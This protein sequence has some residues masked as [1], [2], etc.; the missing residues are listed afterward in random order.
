MR[1]DQSIAFTYLTETRERSLSDS[2]TKWRKR[3]RPMKFEVDPKL[4]KTPIEE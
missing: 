3:K 4:S 1:G 2:A